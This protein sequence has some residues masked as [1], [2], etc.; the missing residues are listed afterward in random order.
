MKYSIV[1]EFLYK[2]IQSNCEKCKL[3][4]LKRIIQTFGVLHPDGV[5]ATFQRAHRKTCM[6]AIQLHY[7]TIQPVITPVKTHD[8]G[9]KVRVSC[10][11][12]C[13]ELVAAFGLC[14]PGI[15][16]QQIKDT[17]ITDSISMYPKIVCPLTDMKEYVKDMLGKE[18]LCESYLTLLHSQLGVLDFNV[19]DI[20]SIIITGKTVNDDAIKAINA[21]VYEISKKDA[22]AD[23]YVLLKDGTYCGISI[24]QSKHATKSNYSV[25]KYFNK[26]EQVLCNETKKKMLCDAGYP[27]FKKEERDVVNALFYDRNNAYFTLLRKLISENKDSIVTSLMNSLYGAHIPYDIY[28][29]DG[30]HLV[31]LD[32]SYDLTKVSFEEHEPF[33]YKKS[34]V[35]RKTAKMFYRLVDGIKAY[36]VEIRWKGTVHTASPQFQIHAL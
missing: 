23:I 17:I 21:S 3:K 32:K 31:K 18:L 11:Y 24:K 14:Y 13:C 20:Q 4:D 16:V 2:T 8:D 5:G 6:N 36:R 28:E 15:T 22:K 27:I 34:G 33:Y 7:K 29:F 19:R 30:T 35:A 10:E 26:E 12:N 9:S 1:N 25:Q